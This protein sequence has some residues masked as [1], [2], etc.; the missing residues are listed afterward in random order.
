VGQVAYTFAGSK[1]GIWGSLGYGSVYEMDG[2]AILTKA[3]SLTAAQVNSYI[4][5]YMRSGLQA[6][7][8]Y[9]PAELTMPAWPWLEAGDTVKVTAEDGTV[10]LVG[11][12]R[13]TMTGVQ[14]L[15]DSIEAPGGE[16]EADDEF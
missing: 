1:A 9:M 13:R 8:R 5:R 14:M 2:N 10:V 7:G 11:I 3:A 12:F 4:S 16:L 15:M 6:L